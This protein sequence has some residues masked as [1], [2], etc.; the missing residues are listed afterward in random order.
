VQKVLSASHLAFD[1]YSNLKKK[2]RTHSVILV[3]S[4]GEL[5]QLYSA[6]DLNFVGGSLVNKRGHN[7]MEAVRWGRPVYYGP[8]IDDFREAAEVLENA[9]GAFRVADGNELAALLLNHLQD[10]K[11]YEQA[12]VNA[13]YAVSLQRGAA[14]RQADILL[15]LLPDALQNK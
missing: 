8:S 6:G 11:V 5:G 13:A 1:L 12:C 15:D 9:G 3:D 10:K 7:I 14:G 2:K 4:M